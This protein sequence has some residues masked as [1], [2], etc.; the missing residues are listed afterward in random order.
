MPFTFKLCADDYAL[1]AGVSIGILE[2]LSV[3]RLTSTSVMTNRP[4]WPRA[5][6]DLARLAP[7]AEVGLHLN[8]TLGAP[9]SPMPVFAPYKRFP[10]L[11]R[12]LRQ[13][14][15]GRLPEAEIRAEI[16]AQID[17]FEDCF[18]RPP[19]YIDGHQHVHVLHGVRQQLFDELAERG[20][21][22]RAW[23]RNSSDRLPRIYRRQSETT[24][25]LA[26]AFFARGF[27]GQARARGFDCNDG[28]AGFSRFDPRRD[29]AIDFAS[30]LVAPGPRHLVMCHPG[31]VDDELIAADPVTTTRENELA[32]LLS[33]RFEDILG[34]AR[35]RIGKW[36]HQ[37]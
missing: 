32:F 20:L 26:L 28:F 31:H 36:T 37:D 19:D 21:A 34:A 18:G 14:R 29:Y 1:S 25:A 2:A 7:H 9:L 5:A 35:A 6:P 4:L 13:A 24:K 8:L 23:L 16:A 15:G 3:G 17:A 30:Y 11:N 22:G 33:P 10:D 27:A 12:V